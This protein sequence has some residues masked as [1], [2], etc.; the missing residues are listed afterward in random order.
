VPIASLGAAVAGTTQVQLPTCV[1]PGGEPDLSGQFRQ[2]VSA[3][4]PFSG[5]YFPAS[6]GMH[7]VS[8]PA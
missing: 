4:A 2:V 5:E 7:A 6:Q 3:K 8:S 1:L